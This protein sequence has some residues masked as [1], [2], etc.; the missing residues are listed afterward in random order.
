M[1]PDQYKPGLYVWYEPSYGVRFL[2]KTV[3]DKP[4]KLGDT[5]VCSV[6]M[7]NGAYGTWRLVFGGPGSIVIMSVPAAALDA[8]YLDKGE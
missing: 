6:A 2:G 1:T 7:V 4:R 3:D 5:W 8:L